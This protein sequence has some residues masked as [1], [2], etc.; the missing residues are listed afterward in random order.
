MY[1]STMRTFAGR[2]FISSLGVVIMSLAINIFITPQHL[3]TTGLMGYAQLIS[4]ILAEDFGINLPNINLAGVL[5]YV[6]SLPI[7]IITYRGLGRDFF[8][9]TIAFSLLFSLTTALIPVPEQPVIDDMI[10][11]VIVGAIGIGVGDGMV[12]TCG[13]SVGGLDMLGMYLSKRSGMGVG[14][15]TIFANMAMFALCLL[16]YDFDIVLYSVIMM[17]FMSLILDRM[18]QQII[19]VQALIFTKCRDNRMTRQIMEETGRGVT[20]W[21]GFGAYTSEPVS[22]LCVC[23]NRYEMEQLERIV[24]GVDPN[25]FIVCVNGVHI[26]G[27]FLHKV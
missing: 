18:H 2:M 27:N 21:E 11:S 3:F 25:A 16:R 8:I 4:A 22:V 26:N 24:K 10:T 17:V 9:R 23:I 12:L 7:F 19:N 6:F 5:Y 15:F 20:G 14:K 1:N 13:C